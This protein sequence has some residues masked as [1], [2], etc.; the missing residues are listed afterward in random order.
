MGK[1]ADLLLRQI[2]QKLTLKWSLPYSQIV[3]YVRTRI[4]IAVTRATHLCLR[5]SRV[6]ASRISN[7]YPSWDDGAGLHLMK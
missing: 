3:N 2:A 7:K 1:E 4:S 6:P 5:G